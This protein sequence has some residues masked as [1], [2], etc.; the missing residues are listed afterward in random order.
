L[1]EGERYIVRSG[2]VLNSILDMQSGKHSLHFVVDS[3]LLPYSI[4]NIADNENIH[5]GVYYFMYLFIYILLFIYIIYYI[6]FSSYDKVTITLLNISLLSLPPPFPNTRCIAFNFDG[7]N[8]DYYK[9]NMLRYEDGE[10]I[11]NINDYCIEN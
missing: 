6:Q 5:I 10:E 2:A 3:E 8:V 4:E 9:R 7:S 11:P 1:L